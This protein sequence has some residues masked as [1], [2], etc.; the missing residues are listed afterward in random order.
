MSD[1]QAIEGLYY[2]GPEFPSVPWLKAV[3]LYWEGI[4][5][6]VPDGRTPQDSPDVKAL[7]EAGAVQDVSPAPF[8]TATAEAF[9][10]RLEDLLQSRQGQPIEE[11]ECTDGSKGDAKAEERIHLTE[12]D[13]SLVKKLESKKLVSVN[14]EWAHMSRAIAQLYRITLANE[15][16]RQLY[17]APVT[18]T[19]ACDVV[20]TYFSSRKVTADPKGVPTDGLQWAQLHLPFP[21]VETAGR[22]SVKKLLDL[23][24]KHAHLRQGFRERI[25]KHTDAIADLP[26]P[27]A[28]H[29][30]L[31]AM[32]KEMQYDLET[33]KDALRAAG[34]RDLWTVISISSPLSL[35]TGAALATAGSPLAAVGAFGVVG[36]GVAKWFFERKAE[37]RESGHYLLSLGRDVEQKNMISDFASRMQ[38]LIHGPA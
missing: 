20:S 3:L 18:D 28:V 31:E 4:L 13:R 5:R 19:T 32:G 6:I 25:Q 21:S 10:T 29:S 9:G 38:H 14:G 34:L 8:R 27:D 33:Q 12:L 1:L 16:A 24:K 7:L 23:R 26:S 11:G 35:G 30:H 2:P 37:R 22:L 17:A 36:L 15:A